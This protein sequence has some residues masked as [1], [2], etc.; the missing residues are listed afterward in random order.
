MRNVLILFPYL[1]I[2]S[3]IERVKGRLLFYAFVSLIDSS[4]TFQRRP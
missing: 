4:R 2:T 1:I 3:D